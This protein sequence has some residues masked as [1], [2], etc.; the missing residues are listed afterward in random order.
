MKLQHFLVVL[1]ACTDLAFADEGSKS[2][3][4]P[5]KSLQALAETNKPKEGDQFDVVKIVTSQGRDVAKFSL[6]RTEHMSPRYVYRGQWSPDSRFFVFSTLSSGGHS[7]WHATTY[8]FDSKSQKFYELDKFIGSVV[9]G[10]F[11]VLEPDIIETKVNN[12]KV[13][14]DGDPIP[15]RVSLV[16]LIEA[17]EK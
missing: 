16:K 13:G 14:V 10:N 15:K 1:L 11:T 6:G 5:N 17:K 9:E 2:W 12:P 4:S 8:F 7:I 3:D